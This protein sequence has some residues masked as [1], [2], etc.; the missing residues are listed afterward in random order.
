MLYEIS[1]AFSLVLLAH[2]IGDYLL[3]TQWMADNKTTRWSPAI[4]HGLAYT[5]PF[6]I[7]THS[8][9]ALL[10]I[11]VTHIL[12]DRFRLAKYV[13][14]FK[15]QFVPKKDRYGWGHETNNKVTGYPKRV[16]DFMAI[17]LMII[18][19]NTLHLI[20]GVLAVVYL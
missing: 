9:P 8:I 5:L 3:Q 1:M 18:A 19:D 17:W 10:V 2:L 4:W 11:C 13:S 7:I 20:I 14:W 6:I 12:I 15:N 16:P